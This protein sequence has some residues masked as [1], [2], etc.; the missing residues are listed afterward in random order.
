MIPSGDHELFRRIVETDD[1]FVLTTHV[2][3]DGDAIGS[4][5]GLARFLLERGKQVHIINQ[6][7]TPH[8]LSF[9]EDEL[10]RVEEEAAV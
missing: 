5:L 9:L 2:N 3:P 7:A 1:R 10:A 4:E 6:D 8:T